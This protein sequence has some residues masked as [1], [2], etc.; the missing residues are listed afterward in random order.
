MIL[1]W[2]EL[3]VPASSAVHIPGIDNRQAD[4]PSRKGLDPDEWSIF[5]KVFQDLA[6]RFNN[7]V[8]SFFSSG[9]EVLCWLYRISIT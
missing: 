3:H 5:P 4:Y 9:A 8:D 1:S 7:K 6:S 2:A